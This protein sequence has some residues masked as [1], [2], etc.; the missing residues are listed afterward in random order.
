MAVPVG[1]LAVSVIY[2]ALKTRYGIGGE[3]LTSPIC[4]KWAGFAELLGQGFH[5]LPRGCFDAMLVAVVLGIIITIL[6]PK[7]RRLVPSPTG[8]GIGMLVPGL[9]VM[10]MV[11]GGVCQWLWAKAHPKSENAYSLPLSSGFICG[12]AL[13]VLVFAIQA[14]FTQ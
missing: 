1:S 14:I 6:E 12:E 3:G 9:A 7:H 8:V 2:P 5:M 10:P 4:V 11:A 13:V